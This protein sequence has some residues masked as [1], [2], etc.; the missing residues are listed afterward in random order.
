M[1]EGSYPLR[2]VILRGVATIAFLGAGLGGWAAT[3]KIEGAVVAAAVIETDADEIIMQ[4]PEGG[5]VA[6]V[7][8]REGDR[9]KAGET[10]LRFDPTRIDAEI[11]EADSQYFEN[12]AR[13][14]R[15]EAERNESDVL[16]FAEKIIERGNEDADV[17]ELMEGQERLFE[18]RA[19]ALIRAAEQRELVR[20]RLED[21]LRAIETE[22]R[23]LLVET[24]IVNEELVD[25]QILF[26][27]GLLKMSRVRGLRRTE[28][29]LEAQLETLDARA[30]AAATQID[31]LE[32]EATQLD[33]KRRADQIAEL[34]NVRAQTRL[35]EAQRTALAEDR[36]RLEIVAP[37]SGTVHDLRVTGGRLV[38]GPRDPMM[39]LVPSGDTFHAMARISPPDID[40]VW[41]GQPVAL[42]LS[43]LDHQRTPSLDGEVMWISADALADRETGQSYYRAE[44][45]FDVGDLP[46]GSTLV[47]G[48]PAEAF[49]GTGA[50][51][52]LSYLLKPLT[53][54][55]SRA[56]REA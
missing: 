5:V 54:Y 35:V 20:S 46:E 6:A 22:R 53:D 39:T 51:T 2:P 26:D 47:P 17:A 40:R 48:M 23:G 8:V 34:R 52:P 50:R 21:D 11:A 25:Q 29:R 56:F 15:L 14:A 36:R 41:P 4:H 18:A 32:A 16:V 19:I 43:A 28:S 33:G 1:S 27:K 42:R 7:P 31:E 45:S 10:I 9:V 13:I 12:L 24:E 37:I 55:M 38:I 3:A 44:I 30:S 49:L